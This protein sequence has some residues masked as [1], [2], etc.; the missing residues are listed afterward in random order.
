MD[1]RK[2]KGA[3]TEEQNPVRCREM[4]ERRRRKNKEG[5]EQC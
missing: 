1:F 3:K 5:K 2:K 4:G